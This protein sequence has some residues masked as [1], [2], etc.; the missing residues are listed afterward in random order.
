MKSRTRLFE[1]TDGN[2]SSTRVISMWVIFM[3]SCLL[4][5]SYIFAFYHVTIAV[6]IIGTSSTAFSII[7]GATFMFL[8]KQKVNETNR[9]FNVSS[10]TSSMSSVVHD[11]VT[12]I[13]HDI[14]H[15]KVPEII[16]DKVPDIPQDVESN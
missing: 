11:K 15:D 6:G 3:A 9:D 1:D 8:Y 12:D 7:T 14:V 10:L 5:S 2:A 4:I 13:V 16:H